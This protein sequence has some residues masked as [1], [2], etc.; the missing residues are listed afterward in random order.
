MDR[1]E[2]L[3]DSEV[4]VRDTHGLLSR[5]AAAVMTRRDFFQGDRRRAVVPPL[6]VP[7]SLALLAR[8]AELADEGSQFV[9]A[10]HSPILVALPG[11]TIM[12]INA[13]GHITPV[14]STTPS[15]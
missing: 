7:S 8:I 10:T 14:T 15:T 11:A 1:L 13:S 2:Y 12:Q 5:I 9:I 4:R 6:S 3:A